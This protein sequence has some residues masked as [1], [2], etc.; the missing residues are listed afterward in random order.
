MSAWLEWSQQGGEWARI[1]S[2]R[3]AARDQAMKDLKWQN[4]ELGF[5]YN[6]IESHSRVL[7]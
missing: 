2:E 6:V 7:S 4:K 1:G 5:S 3:Q